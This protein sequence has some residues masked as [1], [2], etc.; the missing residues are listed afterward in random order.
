M[1]FASGMQPVSRTARH[2]DAA[3]PPTY[4]RK[5]VRDDMTSPCSRRGSLHLRLWHQLCWFT[6]RLHE[7]AAGSEALP[8]RHEHLAVQGADVRTSD[9]D[10]AHRIAAAEGLDDAPVL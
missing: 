3:A 2:A 7:R 8:Q 6:A 4:G 1:C 9:L 5:R 10:G